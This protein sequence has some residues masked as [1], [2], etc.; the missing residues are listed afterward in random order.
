MSGGDAGAAAPV[1]D[2]GP[3]MVIMSQN[4][5]TGLQSQIEASRQAMMM[6]AQN[7]QLGI[8]TNMVTTL[9]GLDVKMQI[10]KMQYLERVDKYDLDYEKAVMRHEENLEEQRLEHEMDMADAGEQQPHEH[11]A[12][13]GTGYNTDFFSNSGGNDAQAGGQSVFDA[14]QENEE[15][16]RGMPPV[17]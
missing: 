15:T 13:I 4:Q 16:R 12:Q 14:A 6:N 8:L 11:T 7:Q 2:Y 3:E 5:L 10:A 1:H 17:N 9:E